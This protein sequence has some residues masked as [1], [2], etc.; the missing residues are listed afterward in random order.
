MKTLAALGFMSDCWENKTEQNLVSLT[1]GTF[2]IRFV[3]D[4]LSP[5]FLPSDEAKGLGRG[6]LSETQGQGLLHSRKGY[7]G[8]RV[9]LT[10]AGNF[11]FFS[12]HMKWHHALAHLAGEIEITF[13]CQLPKTLF[14]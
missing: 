12:S 11:P 9:T 10:G 14:T 3:G 8:V 5:P 6:H 2:S 7:G 1:S 4:R 13:P